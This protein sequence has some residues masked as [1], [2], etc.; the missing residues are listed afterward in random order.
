VVFG[1]AAFV[2]LIFT[3]MAFTAVVFTAAALMVVPLTAMAPVAVDDS[4][5]EPVYQCS[6][7]RTEADS[8]LMT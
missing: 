6:A 8:P 2:T 7:A 1:A 4:Y 5:N 3:G